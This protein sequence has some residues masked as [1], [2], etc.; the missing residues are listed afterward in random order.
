MTS[1]QSIPIH[2]PTDPGQARRTAMTM[3]SKI[4]LGENRAGEVGIIV[5]EC[6]RN[7]LSHA[8][9]GEVLLKPWTFE[10]QKGIDVFALDKGPGI[11]DLE[12]SLEDGYS[13]AGTPG[14]GLGAIQRLASAFHVYSRTGKGTALFARVVNGGKQPGPT[15]CG[16]VCIPIRGETACGDALAVKPTAS[17]YMFIVADGLGHGPMAAEASEAAIETFAESGADV[18]PDEILSDSHGR[19]RSTRGAAVAIA[20]VNLRAGTVN[21]AGIGNISGQ[22]ITGK[23]RRSMISL[24]GTVGHTAHKVQQFSYPWSPDSML[25]M[26]S[27]GIAT[28]W[29]FAEYPGLPMVPP[30]LM[31]AVMYRDF[32]RKRDDATFLVFRPQQA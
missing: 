13:T 7:I 21:Y 3:A 16:D 31:A 32:A 26:H 22:I 17:G 15:D 4:G 9:S 28:S 6:A 20:D 29:D 14:N 11:A 1:Q 5:T 24:N 10:N 19:L 18:G 12:R 8:R 2:E 23:A 25:V 27:D 30:G